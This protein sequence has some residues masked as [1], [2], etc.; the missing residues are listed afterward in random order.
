MR[1]RQPAGDETLRSLLVVGATAVIGAARR[2]AS[3]LACQPPKLAAAALANKIARVAGTL[4]ARS[5]ACDIARAR[6]A[7]AAAA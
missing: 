1:G 7:V 6:P 5:E 2:S 3:R 4:M